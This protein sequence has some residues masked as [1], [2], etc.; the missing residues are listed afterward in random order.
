[1]EQSKKSLYL[2]TKCGI[3]GNIIVSERK[4]KKQTIY[5]I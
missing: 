4:T 2:Y 5:N 1:M 3:L